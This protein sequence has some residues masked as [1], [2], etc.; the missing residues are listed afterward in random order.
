MIESLIV[1]GVVAVSIVIALIM[2]ARQYVGGAK[3]QSEQVY[4]VIGKFIDYQEK[5]DEIHR[6]ESGAHADR[7]DELMTALL[8]LV[9]R[10]HFSKTRMQAMAEIQK[11]HLNDEDAPELYV[12]AEAEYDFDEDLNDD[13]MVSNVIASLHSKLTFEETEEN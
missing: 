7:L 5:R 10:E 13:D 11:Q 6:E 8:G 9:E 2:V 1:L 4:G 3:A 12:P